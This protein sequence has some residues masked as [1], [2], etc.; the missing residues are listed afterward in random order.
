MAST[1]WKGHLTFGLVSIP[2]RLYSA[3]RGESISFNQL[4]KADNSRI[5]QVVYCAAEDKPIPRSEIVKGYEYEK[6]RY[7]VIE[8]EEVKKVAPATAKTME[9]QEFVKA[10]EVDPIYLET[11]YYLA[12][13]EAGE[14]AYALLFDALRKTGYYGVAKIAMHNREHVVILRPGKNGVLLHTMFYSHEIRKVDEFRTDLSLVK[15]KELAMATSL[16]E[17][18]V[19]EFEPDKYKDDYRDNLLQM[20]EAKKKGQEVIAP[21]EPKEAKVVDIMEALKAS[22]AMAKKPVASATAESPA[23]EAKPARRRRAGG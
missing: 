16:I 1:V 22:L 20:I 10:D 9:I 15:E 17:A 19:A 5:R 6:D 3:A 11:S 13:D 2:V 4:H 14:K 12:P 18:M 7:V 23:E 8:D 21:P